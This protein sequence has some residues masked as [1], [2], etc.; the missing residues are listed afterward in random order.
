MKFIKNTNALLGICVGVLTLLCVLSVA[1]PLRFDRQ[2][3]ERETAVKARLV[4]IRSAEEHYRA[5]HGSYAE[6]FGPLVEGGFLADS[7]RYIP[8]TDHKPFQLTASTVIGK[9][10][11]HIPLMECSATY[12]QYL[13]GLDKNSVANLIEEA[14]NAGRYPGLKVGDITE[15]NGNAGNWE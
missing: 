11:K 1:S 2:R 7:L 15:P 3:A 5:R 14:N 4:A 6:S 13:D 12:D 8:Y 9:S 10:G